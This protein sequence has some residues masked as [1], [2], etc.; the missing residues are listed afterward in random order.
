[1]KTRPSIL[2]ESALPVLILVAL[3]AFLITVTMK[4]V[5]DLIT[6]LGTVIGAVTGVILLL[7]AGWKSIKSAINKNTELTQLIAAA[8]EAANNKIEAADK[9]IDVVAVDAKETKT[10]LA[11]VKDHINGMQD[12]LL[13][14]TS[15]V[16]EGVGVKLGIEEGK[17]IE[18]EKQADVK[19]AR[20]E[21]K[22]EG[23][24]ELPK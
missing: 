7:I 8:V 14:A 24:S 12:K 13:A 10:E 3:V 4:D 23:Q 21:G 11:A 2:A 15:K 19:I 6:S 5:T 9:K 18:Q 22:V 16:A 17:K 1:M 20:D